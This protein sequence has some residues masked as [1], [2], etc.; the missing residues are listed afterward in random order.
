VV[1]AMVGAMNFPDTPE[2]R[3][4]R[5]IFEYLIEIRT[6]PRYVVERDPAGALIESHRGLR[7][8]IKKLRE[9]LKRRESGRSSDV[10]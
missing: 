8:D 1:G 10:S 2:G 3:D 6:A 5:R 4:L 7:A 9:L